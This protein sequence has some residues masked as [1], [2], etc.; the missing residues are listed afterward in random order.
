[1]SSRSKDRKILMGTLGKALGLK[2]LLYFKYH[3]SDPKNLLNF[4]YL[5]LED[6]TK[7]KFLEVTFR[8]KRLVVLIRGVQDRESA[9][10]LKNKEVFIKENQLPI[11][12]SENY[13]WYQLEG[14]VV[15]N[16]QGKNL[17][18]ISRMLETGA[19]DV[20]DVRP[21]KNS[22]DNRERLIPYLREEVIK[23][24][25]LTKGKIYVEWHESY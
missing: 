10:E 16:I 19:N 20:I 5:F 2:G 4:D 14:L 25:D 23:K 6:K 17:G 3:G 21:S 8:K 24:V 11:L 9:E 12:D 7:I 18:K 1:M 15:E 13:Y 22:I